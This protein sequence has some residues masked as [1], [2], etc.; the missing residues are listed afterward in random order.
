MKRIILGLLVL[1]IGV[2]MAGCESIGKKQD[3][4]L[5]GKNTDE[6]VIMCLKQTYPQNSFRVITPFDKNKNHGIYAD[7][8]GVEFKVHNIL[9]DNFYHFGCTDE[10][11]ATL[12]KE[13]HYQE[14]AEIIVEKYG[15]QSR[16]DDEY[17]IIDITLDENNPAAFTDMAK[18]I[19]EV[20][21]SVTIPKLEYPMNQEFSTGEVNYFSK[22]TWGILQ[23]H[24]E[25]EEITVCEQFFFSDRSKSVS[26]IE[27]RLVDLN[28]FLEEEI[29]DYRKTV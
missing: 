23:I 2:Y 28:Q 1:S 7:E 22:P 10:Y 5:D 29:V 20:L 9:Y 13:Q 21:N 11:L 19:L 24:L 25:R 15:Q 6:R 27:A 14:K 3:N 17:S 12:L 26:E 16:F 4:P 8:E 18:M